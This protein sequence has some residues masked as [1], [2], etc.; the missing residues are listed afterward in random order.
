MNFGKDKQHILATNKSHSF[1]FKYSKRTCPV[2]VECTQ[3]RSIT[4][5]QNAILQQA[6]IQT[7]N[8]I[9]MKISLY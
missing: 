7:V 4:L 1:V 6:V 9:R 8:Q 2:I 3:H 5:I